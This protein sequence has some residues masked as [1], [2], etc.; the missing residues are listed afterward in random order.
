MDDSV[1]AFVSL[2]IYEEQVT[3][4]QNDNADPS[5]SLMYTTDMR[6]PLRVRDRAASEVTVVF[7]LDSNGVLFVRLGDP[8]TEGE[9]EAEGKVHQQQILLLL[10][11]VGLLMAVY[12]FVRFYFSEELA[13]TLAQPEHPTHVA[14]L[15]SNDEDEF[16]EL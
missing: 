13:T 15:A 8:A 6:V 7:T 2:D 12:V 11:Y 16:S 5:I 1:Q 9:P 14:E 10:V 3:P 4:G